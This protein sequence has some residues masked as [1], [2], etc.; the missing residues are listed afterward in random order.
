MRA[1]SGWVIRAG[2]AALLAFTLACE[3]SS[4][5]LP[6]ARE[7][8]SGFDGVPPEY[9]DLD[10]RPPARVSVGRN[11]AATWNTRA[12]ATW[13]QDVVTVAFL[14]GDQKVRELIEA[15]ALEWTKHGSHFRFSF[16]TA[17]NQFRV[18]SPR[19]TTPSAEIRIGFYNADPLWGEWSL[20]GVA[21]RRQ[22]PGRPT[23][24]LEGVPNA[25]RGL[26]SNSEEWLRGYAHS[27]VLHEFGHALGLAHEHYHSRCQNDLKFEADPGY[28][29]TRDGGRYIPDLEGRSPGAL[30]AYQGAPHLMDRDLARRNL[31]A[32]VAFQ[33]DEILQQSPELDQ[34]SVMLYDIAPFLLRSGASSPCLNL[35]DVFDGRRRYASA[36]SAGD[37]E[38]F[39][40]N[41]DR[42]LPSVM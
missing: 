19:D 35:G 11:P 24:N 34:Q 38:Y 37:I 30:L 31:I 9:R 18:W 22:L 28:Q 10:V 16:R 39:R 33:H 29:T 32:S 2:V 21:A 7:P 13:N 6:P 26:D 17:D 1:L 41:Y 25:A 15:T 42:P 23:M 40:S 20:L 27:V 12:G 14:G 36:L 5:P 3:G 8:F 4:E